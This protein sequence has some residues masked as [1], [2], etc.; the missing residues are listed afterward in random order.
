MH[1]TTP[2]LN[3]IILSQRIAC[4]SLSAHRSAHYWM[5]KNQRGKINNDYSPMF[6]FNKMYFL[7]MV[8]FYIGARMIQRA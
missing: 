3:F 1:A 2:R 4:G 5:K 7:L 6:V 8:R